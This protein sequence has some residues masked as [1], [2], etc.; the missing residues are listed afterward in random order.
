MCEHCEAHVKEALE[1]IDGVEYAEASHTAGTAEV[2][3][4]KDVSNDAMKAAVEKEGYT[5][6]GITSSE[7]PICGC[8]V[9]S[10][11][12]TRTINIEGMMC[13]HCE[14][15]VKEAL[16]AIDGVKSASASHTAG[17]AIVT[18]TKD[19]ADDTMKTAVEKEG[20]AVQSIR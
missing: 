5:V 7:A 14:A 20:Y 18:L 8:S 2:T 6:H 17:T 10:P 4:T 16:E 12:E 9:S 15:H 1:A 3:L 13:E 11:D 19:V